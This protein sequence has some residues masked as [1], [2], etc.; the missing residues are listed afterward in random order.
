[1]QERFVGSSIASCHMAG[2]VLPGADRLCDVAL[3][4]VIGQRSHVLPPGRLGL[5]DA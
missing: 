2:S 5:R 1:M 4:V 3:E